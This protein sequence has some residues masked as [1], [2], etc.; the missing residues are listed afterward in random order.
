MRRFESQILVISPCRMNTSFS[1]SVFGVGVTEAGL[2]S[3][4]TQAMKD[5]YEMLQVFQVSIKEGK[6]RQTRDKICVVCTD[7]VHNNGDVIRGCMEQIAREREDVGMQLFLEQNVVFLNSMV[8][9]ITSE[10]DGSSGM[11]PRC[12]P[13][14]AKALVIL[15][16][17]NNLPPSL[18]HQSGVVVRNAQ[19]QLETDVALK[20]RIANGTHTAI[21]H[22]LA[23]LQYDLTTILSTDVPGALFMNYL[24][25]LVIDQ[26]AP[27]AAMSVA[28]YDEALD[29]WR[30]WKK[31]LL[32]PEFGLSSFFITQNG[33]IKGGIR[34]GDTVREL[35][36]RQHMVSVSFAFAYA[37]LLRWLTPGNVS[38]I[39]SKEGVFRGWLD[40]SSAPEGPNTN[41]KT[42][43]VVEYAD[44]LFHDTVHGWYEFKC[45]LCVQ[46][47]SGG[48][49]ILPQLLHSCRGKQP[50]GCID[51]VRAYLVAE[52]GGRLGSAASTTGFDSLVG[53]VATLY[54]RLLV[55]DGLHQILKELSN[56]G[57]DSSCS[58]LVDNVASSWY[59]LTVTHL[60]AG[61]LFVRC[62]VPCQEVCH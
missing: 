9:R 21:A 15:D 11:V 4:R 1:I 54:S 25:S 34:W 16:P 5:M 56:R 46:M 31:R 12:E 7:N 8:D 57:F 13:I 39:E 58:V 55:G 59:P 37:A 10:R 50:A 36:H 48:H 53:A 62:R 22:T 32:H 27:A 40:E 42:Q 28:T 23:L 44:G 2:A 30:D 17:H 45:D 3:S 29:V 38:T 20:L 35:L 19:Q 41:R 33:A 18:S 49:E 14:P 26:I 43:S 51:A 60:K 47:A 6:W 24:E 52:N 61:E